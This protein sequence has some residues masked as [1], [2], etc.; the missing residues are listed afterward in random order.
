MSHTAVLFLTFGIVLVFVVLRIRRMTKEQ[1]F[2]ILTMWVVPALFALIALA[3]MLGEHVT[4]P[5]DVVFAAFAF[6]AGAAIGYYQGRHTTVRVDRAARAMFVKVSPIGVAIFVGV[7]L[8][9]VL[10]RGLYGGAGQTTLNNPEFN[11]MSVLALMLVVGMVLGL[12]F[13]LARVYAHTAASF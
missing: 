2:G 3:I 13:Y 5:Q 10:A 1:R 4:T 9:R 11:L 6:A 7:L 8:M 12:R